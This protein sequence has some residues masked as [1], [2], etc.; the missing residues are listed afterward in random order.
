MVLRLR[1]ETL[2]RAGE[3]ART[4]L[5]AGGA[6]SG[7]VRGTA[8]LRHRTSRNMALAWAAF[9]PRQFRA[10]PPAWCAAVFSVPAVW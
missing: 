1:I 9:A 3:A 10:V 2:D 6:E 7:V 5:N 4:A 8:E